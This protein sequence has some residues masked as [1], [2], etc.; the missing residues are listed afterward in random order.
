[1]ISTDVTTAGLTASELV[2][3]SRCHMPKPVSDFNIDSRRPSG[4]RTECRVCQSSYNRAFK[5]SKPLYN[6]W[7]LMLQRCYSATNPAF[8][9]YGARGIKVCERWHEY[10]AFVADMSP[11]PSPKHS[12]DRIDVNG[13]YCPENCRWATQQEQVLNL[14]SNRLITINGES[15][16]LAEWARIHG[17]PKFTV[18]A[19]VYRYGWDE[20]SAVTTPPRQYAKR[21][22][23]A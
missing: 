9:F 4:R 18:E 13:D 2:A 22:T 19:R 20:V 15:R 17:I 1:M 10:E 7:N 5:V 14:R 11:R 8:R 12:I 16:P 6:I 3:C 23:V 21:S